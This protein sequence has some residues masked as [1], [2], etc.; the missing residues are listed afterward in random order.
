MLIAPGISA[1]FLP[2]ISEMT[3]FGGLTINGKNNG[4]AGVAVTMNLTPQMGLEGEI[5]VIFTSDEKITASGNAVLN[6]GYGTSFIVP[7]LTGGA[8]LINNGGTDIALNLGGGFKVF[9][10]PNMALRGDFRVFLTTDEG[11]VHDLER[12]YAGIDFLF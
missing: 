1:Q 5:G 9:F 4:T 8:G 10:E 11:D 2:G 12:F 6:L 3:G 7:Y